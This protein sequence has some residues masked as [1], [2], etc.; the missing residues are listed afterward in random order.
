MA[1]K[2]L[3]Q[4]A[5][6]VLQSLQVS[7]QHELQFPSKEVDMA[8]TVTPALMVQVCAMVC[9]SELVAGCGMEVTLALSALVMK[10]SR[11]GGGGGG[12]TEDE[13][14]TDS[15]G[16]DVAAQDGKGQEPT[17]GLQVLGE[18]GRGRGQAS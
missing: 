13:P 10:A 15:H 3:F 9:L 4:Q 16:T 17:E 8:L 2:S 5:L 18:P 7:A 11:E 1:D 12:G 6:M 14:E